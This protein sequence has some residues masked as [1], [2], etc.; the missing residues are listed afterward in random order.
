MTR[1]T[2]NIDQECFDAA[3]AALMTRNL[4]QIGYAIGLLA[5]ASQLAER[6]EPPPIPETPAGCSWACRLGDKCP[7]LR[8]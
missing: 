1:K 3:L 5:A 7:S 2:L 4:E 6:P 8:K